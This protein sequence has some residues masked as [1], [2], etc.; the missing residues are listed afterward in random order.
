MKENIVYKRV[1]FNMR[2][3][4]ANKTLDAFVAALYTLVKHYSYA[5]MS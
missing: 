4:E 2:K 3:Q 1:L 5:T